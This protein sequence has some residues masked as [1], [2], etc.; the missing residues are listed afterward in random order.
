[1]LHLWYRCI[2]QDQEHH[3][4]EEEAHLVEASEALDED[5]FE[6]VAQVVADSF[7]SLLTIK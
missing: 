7:I 2:V 6:V 4:V 1:M 3:E 5:H